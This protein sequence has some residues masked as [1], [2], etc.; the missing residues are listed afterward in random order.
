[1]GGSSGSGVG[2]GGS[3]DGGAANAQSTAAQQELQQLHSA[4][5]AAL[6]RTLLLFKL[7]GNLHYW[8]PEL[9]AHMENCF[10]KFILGALR[11]SFGSQQELRV[12]CQRVNSN[13]Q[14]LMDFLE[15]VSPD[16]ETEDDGDILLTQLEVDLVKNLQRCVVNMADTAWLEQ[17]PEPPG[18]AYPDVPDEQPQQQPDLTLLAADARPAARPAAATDAIVLDAPATMRPAGSGELDGSTGLPPVL[19]AKQVAPGSLAALGMAVHE[20][21]LDSNLLALFGPLDGPGKVRG[22]GGA[23]GGGSS[24]VAQSP[25]AVKSTAGRQQQQQ[26][27][28]WKPPVARPLQP[29]SSALAAFAA[30]AAAAAEEDSDGMF[31]DCQEATADDDGPAGYTTGYDDSDDQELED[32]LGNPLT[33]HSSEPSSDDLSD[34]AHGAL[35]DCPDDPDYGR[36]R[37]PSAV[38]NFPQE[39]GLED[40]PPGQQQWQLENAA[41]AA[42]DGGI[43]SKSD[44]EVAEGDDDLM[45]YDS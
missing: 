27:R 41:A 5:A 42:D 28:S 15:P 33:W 9:P 16:D 23:G 1:M 36:I 20:L 31:Y 8:A 22:G 12:A 6:S 40:D 17:F 19:Q 18:P 44:W 21:L 32:E 43:G 3:A 11:T 38:V 45:D 29:P 26:S 25:S 34:E 39:A 7:L 24:V 4:K 10:A 2:G 35:A 30:A 13:L 14:A 37:G